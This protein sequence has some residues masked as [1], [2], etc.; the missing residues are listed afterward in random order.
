MI[1][2]VKLVIIWKQFL[3]GVILMGKTIIL[4]EVLKKEYETNYNDFEAVK[5]KFFKRYEFM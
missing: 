4:K 3:K 1:F 5:K 2:F